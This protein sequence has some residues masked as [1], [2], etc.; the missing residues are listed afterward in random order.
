MRLP[1]CV[2]PALILV[3]FPGLGAGA[4]LAQTPAPDTSAQPTALA[5]P[6]P[7][8]AAQPAA[9]AAPAPARKA[10]IVPAGTKVLLQL[11]S[12]INTKSAKPGDGVY[13]ASTFPVVVGNRVMIPA[14]VYVQGVVD[15][16]VR[17]G[18]V[19]GRAQ[20]D[21][22]FT[23]MIF[24]NGSV[25]EI[26]GMVNGLPGASR[27]TVKDDGEGTIQ[28][29]GD[30]GRNV[31][32]AAEV[33]IPTGGSIGSIGGYGSGH[34]IAGGLAGVGAGLVAVGAV[35]LFTRGADVNILAGSQVEMVLQRP[36]TLE[37][38][39]LAPAG[40]PGTAPAL[41]PS[42]NQPKPIEK[43]GHARIT[44]PPGGLGCD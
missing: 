42:P 43:P 15:R 37:E 26:P 17:A 14:G 9:S 29:D 31:G 44:C 28:Q 6:V 16:V 34:P 32:R 5:A 24:P 7:D 21:M 25:V 12:A 41:V 18:R 27:Q 20:L 23:S 3:T 19:K 36:L 8:S 39:N 2:F 33:A 4:I 1:H 13:L 22:H 10:Y 30:K 11:R 35:S 38:E 40:A